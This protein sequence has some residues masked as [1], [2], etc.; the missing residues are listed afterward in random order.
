MKKENF[1]ESFRKAFGNYEL[2]IGFWYSDEPVV[3]TEKVKGCYLSS[4]KSVLEGEVISH[5]MD[6]ITCPGGKVHTGFAE[7]PPTIGN[8]VANKEHYKKTPEMV[9]DY[10]SGLAM[11][12]NPDKYINFAPFELIDSFENIEAVIF[13]ATPDVLSGLI[14]WV[15]YDTNK[16]DAV[17]V[18]FGSGCSSIIS[19]A[20]VENKKNGYRTF[21]GMFDPSAR[22]I[23]DENILTLTIPMSRFKVLYDTINESCLQGSRDWN[24][25]KQR[26]NKESNL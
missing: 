14:S 10:F 13:F 20:V 8:F 23:V 16:S 5:S 24:K 4:L 17:S 15:L 25:V 18:P 26:I 3:E 7:M 2:P 9:C 6:S 1:I 12:K 19:E 11:S 21:L 22:P